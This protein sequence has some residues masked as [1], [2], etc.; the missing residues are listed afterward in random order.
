MAA[1]TGYPGALRVRLPIKVNQQRRVVEEILNY[2]RPFGF[3]LEAGSKPELMAVAALASNDSPSSQTA[4]R[5]PSSSRW[6]CSPRRWA[7]TVLPVVR[8]T[9]SS[10]SSSKY[11]QKVGVRPTYWHAREAGLPRQRQMAVVRRL[12]LEFGLTG[13]EV[14]KGFEEAE[15]PRPCRTASSSCISTWAARSQHP[16][17][18]GRGQRGAQDLRR[19]C[20]GRRPARVPR[21]EAASAWTTTARRPTSSRA[22]TTPRRVRGRRRL[23][24]AD[25]VRRRGREAPDDRVESR[26]RLRRITGA[27]LQRARSDRV[28]EQEIQAVGPHDEQSAAHRPAGNVPEPLDPHALES[29]HDAQQAARHG[30]EPVSTAA[31]CR[32]TSG[33]R[34]RRSTGPSARSCND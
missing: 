29:Y 24:R 22:S 10:A 33:A 12:P 4:S 11:S 26:A 30:A 17:R 8:S 14:L 9:A 19:A 20:E 28:R 3:G 31:T 32:S 15:S 16:H 2:R 25:G 21:I 7:A 34:R 6:R 18:E 5:T 23:P 1:K 13:L 27:R